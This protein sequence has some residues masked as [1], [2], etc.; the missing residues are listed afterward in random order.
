MAKSILT[1]VDERALPPLGLVGEDVGGPV[2]V[3]VTGGTVTLPEVVMIGMTAVE[4]VI[5]GPVAVG[6]VLSV[7]LALSVEPGIGLMVMMPSPE[8]LWAAATA[9]M[10]AKRVTVENFMVEMSKMSKCLAV[11]LFGLVGDV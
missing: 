4:E 9:M 5:A 3:L 7:G 2:V 11:W 6:L 10:V 8:E 1:G